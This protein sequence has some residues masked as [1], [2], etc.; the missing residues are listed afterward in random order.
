V[1]ER[2][3]GVGAHEFAD[4]EVGKRSAVALRVALNALA[5]GREIVGRLP[6]PS[7]NCYA[8]KRRP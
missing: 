7:L 3:K 5:I 8:N 6:D 1:P 2:G 4:G